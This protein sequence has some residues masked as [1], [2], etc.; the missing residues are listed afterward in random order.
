MIELYSLMLFELAEGSGYRPQ[1]SQA[2]AHQSPP[3]EKSSFCRSTA[4]HC[5]LRMYLFAP[6][7]RMIMLCEATRGGG[8]L[9]HPALDP[10]PPCHAPWYCWA[11]V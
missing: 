5:A 11:K 4:S 7:P 10:R 3:L 6:Q 1:P 9:P 8:L 2:P